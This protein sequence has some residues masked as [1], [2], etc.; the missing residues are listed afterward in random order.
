MRII[1]P[2]FSGTGHYTILVLKPN[3]SDSA[4]AEGSG[5]ATGNDT[6]AE[7]KV[8]LNLTNA[9]PGIY[10]LATRREGDQAMYYYPLRINN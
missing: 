5:N 3:S 8:R 9:A 2:R 1:L 10:R 6:V 7:V 4:I